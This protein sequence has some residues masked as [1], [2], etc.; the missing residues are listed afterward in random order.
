MSEWLNAFSHDAARNAAKHWRR[1]KK[2]RERKVKALQK[3]EFTKAESRE[4]LAQRANR[5]TSQIKS[6]MPRGAMPAELAEMVRRDPFSAEE[7]D[8]IL[9]ERVLGATSDFLSVDFISRANQAIRSVGRVVVDPPNGRGSLGTGFLITERLLMTNHH[10]LETS[11]VARH[12]TVEFDFQRGADGRPLTVQS[13]SL[14]PETFF[15]AR[16]ELDYAIVAVEPTNSDDVPIGNYSFL[17]LDPRLGKI[18]LNEPL[19]IVQHPLGEIKQVVLRE[20]RLLDLPEDPDFVAHYEGDTEPG[21]SGS[22]VFNDTWEVVALHHSGVPDTNDDGKILNKNGRVWRRGDDPEDISWIANEGIRI[23]RLV[24]DLDATLRG[25]GQREMLDG[26][27]RKLG[28]ESRG[29]PGFDSSDDFTDPVSPPSNPIRQSA[30]GNPE[31]AVLGSGSTSITIPLNI[32]VSLGAASTGSSAVGVK[33]DPYDDDDDDAINPAGIPLA[34]RTPSP[35]ELDSRDGYDR[36]FLGFRA[37]LPTLD[38]ALRDNAKV[39]RRDDEIELRYMHFTTVM[40]EARKLAYFSA[41]NMNRQARFQQNRIDGFRSDPR[42]RRGV[43][44]TNRFYSSNPLDRGHLWR[45]DAGAWGHSRREARAGNDDSYFWTNIAPQHFIFN[46]SGEASDRGLKLWG[47]LEN[48]IAG[49]AESERQKVSVFCGP[50]FSRFDPPHRTLKIPKRYWKI[51][52]YERDNG[53]PGAAGFVLSQSS[54]IRTLP[55]ERLEEFAFDDFS[56]FQEPIN[57]ISRL[58]KL[59]FDEVEDFDVLVDGNEDFDDDEA[60]A[61]MERRIRGFE[62]LVL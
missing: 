14:D 45:R 51:V 27:F 16:E 37:P 56:V 44:A 60:V 55:R 24:S 39:R 50:I 7:M 52:I 53:R 43:Q 61:R 29:G 20:N 47:N 4:H 5:L 8:D 12:S 54:L 18:T 58:T 15:H 62:D 35:A 31:P 36:N 10:V 59:D 22:P 49:E 11:R 23:S 17:E 38:P 1:N 46:Q 13:F 41:G 40:N 33:E 3:G 25:V 30:Q 21:S 57:K 26:L 19:N 32:T 34:E 48:A 2:K 9:F 6:G 28:N 42:V